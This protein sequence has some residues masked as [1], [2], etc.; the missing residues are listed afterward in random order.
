M[1]TEEKILEAARD[2]FM[3]NGYSGCRMRS[4]SDKAGINKGLLHYYF[5]SKDALFLQVFDSTFQELMAGLRNALAQDLHLIEKIELIVDLYSTHFKK[6]PGLPAFV[7]Q[8]ANRDQNSEFLNH[9]RKNM[10]PMAGIFHTAVEQAKEK[11][12]IRAD[13]KSEHLFLSLLSLM[14]FPVLAKPM[15]CVMM[16]KTEEEHQTM[17]E[18]RRAF[19]KQFIKQAIQL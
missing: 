3:L 5:K 18:E 16:N 10:S 1:T 8:E 7:L 19:V 17:M 15:T 11:G 9:K 13:I 14:I 6:N 4:I 2:E 12:E